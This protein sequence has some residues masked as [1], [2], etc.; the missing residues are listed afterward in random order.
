MLSTMLQ[1]EFSGAL[2]GIK[3]P[4]QAIASARLGLT[5]LFAGLR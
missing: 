2:V 1:P 5:H 4:R 3:T